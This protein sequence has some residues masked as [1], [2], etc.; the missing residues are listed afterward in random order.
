MFC[1]PGKKETCGKQVRVRRRNVYLIHQR[2]FRKVTKAI[3]V[4]REGDE[5]QR[6]AGRLY[7]SD[8]TD[9]AKPVYVA[10][11]PLHRGE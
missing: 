5:L 8:I 11:Q 1:G 2:D 6:K 3:G 7:P 10:H 4:N 9:T